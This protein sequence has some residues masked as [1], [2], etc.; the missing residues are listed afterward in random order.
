LAL[1]IGQE[2]Q[3]EYRQAEL[4]VA[5]PPLLMPPGLDISTAGFQVSIIESDQ[6]SA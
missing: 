4:Q 2:E 1:A 6:E 5:G 3:F